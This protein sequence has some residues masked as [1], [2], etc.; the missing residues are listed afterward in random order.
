MA[1]A[2]LVA[3][4]TG[5]VAFTA[6]PAQ[7]QGNSS[8]P[9][10][11]CAQIENDAERLA[12]FDRETRAAESPAVPPSVRQPREPAPER[13]IRN[14]EAAAPAAA[15]TTAPRP[16]GRRGEEGELIPIVVVRVDAIPG[17]G[18]ALVTDS[19]D[20]WVQLD[21][22]REY[23]P[24]VPFDAQLKRGALDSY[25]LMRGKN[26]GAVRVRRWQRPQ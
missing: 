23:Y 21:T 16:F 10:R 1:I 3:I 19:G 13:A 20:V 18:A 7:A 25:S 8:A 14:A 24:P 12:C 4:A 22:Q 2:A 17:R 11:P 5:G 9:A 15:P 6:P 26:G